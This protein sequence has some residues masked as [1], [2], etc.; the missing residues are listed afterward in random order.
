MSARVQLDDVRHGPQ[1]STIDVRVGGETRVVE[2][3]ALGT[4]VVQQAVDELEAALARGGSLDEAIAGVH[5]TDTPHRTQ[6]LRTANNTLVLDDTGA[7]GPSDV[8]AS[9]RVLAD[10]GRTG[11]RTVAVVGPLAVDE[12]DRFDEHDALGRIVVRLDV[13]QLVVIGHDARHLQMAA[14]LEGSWNGESVLMEDVD[15]AYDFVRATSG[16]DAVILVSGGVG[17]SLIDLVERLT[18]ADR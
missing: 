13:R 16:E 12:R 17:L 7:T 3:G 8:R 4:V 15:T 2:L 14:G 6:R 5:L 11:L 9:L 10:L 1:G 18:E